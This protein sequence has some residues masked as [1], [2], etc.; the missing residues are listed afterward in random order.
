VGQ[1]AAGNSKIFLYSMHSHSHFSGSPTD[2]RV[3]VSQDGYLH[4][5]AA[6]HSAT[7][8]L[9]EDTKFVK[10]VQAAA[11]VTAYLFQGDG[12]A[13]AAV[14]PDPAMR[15]VWPIPGGDGIEAFDVYS[16]P[17]PQ[18]S[19]LGS[20]TVYLLGTWTDELEGALK[21]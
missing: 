1:L 17:L 19:L 12:Y 13:V 21:K 18:G 4:P 2:W 15:P 5:S 14:L 10:R 6:A 20:S 16:N 3:L 9:L 8:W 11:G 7:A